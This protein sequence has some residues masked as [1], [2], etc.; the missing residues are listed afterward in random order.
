MS[1]IGG[2]EAAAAGGAVLSPSIAVRVIDIARRRS[3][4]G[5]GSAAVAGLAA[6]ERET[7]GLLGRGYSNAEIAS[8]LF[9][10]EGTVKGYISTIFT[11]LGVRNRVEAAIIA[12]EAGLTREP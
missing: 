7:L 12:H 1:L 6:R 10:V 4:A 2:V 11:Q 9:V 5:L 8:R 3:P